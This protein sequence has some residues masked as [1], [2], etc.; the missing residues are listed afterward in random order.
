MQGLW[1]CPPSGGYALYPDTSSWNTV[2]IISLP[3]SK[4]IWWCGHLQESSLWLQFSCF[5]FFSTISLWELCC[6]KLTYPLSP[7]TALYFFNFYLF[8]CYSPFTTTFYT[9]QCSSEKQN[10]WEICL[11]LCK[12]SVTCSCLSLWNCMGRSQP[13]SSVHGIFQA[14]ILEWVAIFFSQGI[15]LT[16]ELNPCLLYLLHWQKDS[17]PICHLGSPFSL[18]IYLP[19]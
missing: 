7:P 3:H 1:T 18:C 12:C 10:Q 4:D 15:F 8:S 13:S 14:R 11:S 19:I 5:I 17:L 2:I 16:Q 9:S 6:H